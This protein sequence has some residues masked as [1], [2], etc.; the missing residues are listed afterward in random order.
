MQFI[1]LILLLSTSQV[2]IFERSLG[3]RIYIYIFYPT[4]ILCLLIEAGSPCKF[5]VITICFLFVPPFFCFYFPLSYILL[6]WLFLLYLFPTTSLF[7]SSCSGY[8][9]IRTSLLDLLNQSQCISRF[10]DNARVLAFFNSF[11]PISSYMLLFSNSPCIL[12]HKTLLS[13]I[14]AV[15]SLL[16][17]S[18]YLPVLLLCYFLGLWAATW[19]HFPHLRI[20]SFHIDFITNKFGF[21]LLWYEFLHFFIYLKI[22]LYLNFWGLFTG[23]FLLA[24]WKYSHFL[25]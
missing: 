5:N 7:Y 22:Y 17:L 4:W 23:Y 14:F 8:L 1:F 25:E 18:I 24:F 15:N 10:L 13:L 16:D 9:E 3:S 12:N 2:P 11:Y 6:D 21:I 20:A 19:N